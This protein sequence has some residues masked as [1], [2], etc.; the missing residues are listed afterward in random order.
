MTGQKHRWPIYCGHNNTEA[1]QAR[2]NQLACC[3]S[4]KQVL[5]TSVLPLF[6]PPSFPLSFVNPPQGSTAL[7]ITT[8][9]VIVCCSLHVLLLL[10]VLKNECRTKPA[11]LSFKV[12]FLISTLVAASLEIWG[13][14]IHLG[15]VNGK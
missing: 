9:F 6:P 3:L 14:L 1:G 15:A 11:L 2:K 8:I 5:I 12:I 13:L 4:Q 7:L 10:W